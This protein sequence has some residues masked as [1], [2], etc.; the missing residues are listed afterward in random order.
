MLKFPV[1]VY[2]KEVMLYNSY[3]QR[4]SYITWDKLNLKSII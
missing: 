1:G 2:Q 3:L 4:F